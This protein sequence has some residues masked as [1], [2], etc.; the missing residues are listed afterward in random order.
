MLLPFCAINPVPTAITVPSTG[1]SFE[2]SGMIIPPALISLTGFGLTSIL[3]LIGL[4]DIITPNTKHLD[5]TVPHWTN[6]LSF[7]QDRGM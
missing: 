7:R 1:A 5:M 4:T 3:S 2:D 6:K